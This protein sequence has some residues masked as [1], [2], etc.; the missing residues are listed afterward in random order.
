MLPEDVST[1]ETCYHIYAK[2]Y[3]NGL[4]FI[5]EFLITFFVGI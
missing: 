3:D 4:T 1:L 2:T 5:C